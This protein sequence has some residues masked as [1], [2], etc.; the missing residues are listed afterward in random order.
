MENIIK[1]TIEKLSKENRYI[2]IHFEETSPTIITYMGKELENI[3]VS[4]SLKGNIRILENG[5]WFFYSFN[6]DID[7]GI[8]E[9]VEK[10]I[11]TTTCIKGTSKIMSYK[12]VVDN[13]KTECKINPAEVT[14]EEKN[15]IIKKYNEMIINKNLISKS[16]Y[17]D[18]YKK[19]YF[20]NSEGS[21]ITQEKT[22]TGFSVYA[23]I[24]S[25]TNVEQSFFSNAGYGGLELVKGFEKEVEE[26][27]KNTLDLLK[28]ESVE[29]GRYNVILDPRI[30]GVFAHEAFGHL[31]EADFIYENKGMLELMKI[32][33]EFGVRELNII[34][35]GSIPQLAG[36]TPYDDEGVKTNRNYLIKD[37]FLSSRLHSRETAYKMGESLTGNARALDP[38]YKPIVRMTNTFIDK[39]NYKKDE[40]FDIL[41]DG[42][43]CVDYIGGMTNLE[44]FTFTPARS[45]IIKNGKPVKLVKNAVLSGNVFETLRKIKAIG[46]DLMHFGTLGGC[47]KGGQS[48]LP[49]TVGAPHI[50]LED[51]I[52]G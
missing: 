29:K 44:M 20:A 40:L 17:K 3:T 6:K 21:F 25:G 2:E 50:L 4:Q 41:K 12:K 23:M 7:S 51:I 45:Y 31:S 36:Y 18:I 5:N 22:F 1:K 26:V 27:I 47:G 35:D 15:N 11:K 49:V 10:L 42:I 38:L 14:L 43:Y 24:R 34:D 19:I 30:A 16:V 8:V 32:G 28:A 48:G 39:G 37:G 46:N 9:K 52:I 13:I 33:K